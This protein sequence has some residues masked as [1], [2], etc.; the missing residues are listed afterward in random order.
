MKNNSNR[1]WI[2]LLLLLFFFVCET[3]AF[4]DGV[5]V[6]RGVKMRSTFE[7]PRRGTQNNTS[8]KNSNRKRKYI[9]VPTF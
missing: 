2:V 4:R 5:R 6:R 7:P 9:P 8:N 3:I 1:N